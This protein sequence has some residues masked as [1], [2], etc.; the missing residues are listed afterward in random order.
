MDGSCGI[1]SYTEALL[2]HIGEAVDEDVVVLETSKQGLAASISYARTAFRVGTTD[3]DVIHVQHEYG[4]FGKKWLLLWAF[5]PIVF[6]LARLRRR[7]VVITLHEAW[8][9][10]RMDPPLL[11]L[12]GAYI[13]IAN[14]LIASTATTL[15]FLSEN[16][17][18]KFQRNGTVDDHRLL[19]HGVD[20]DEVRPTPEE[21][22]KA[23]F[24]FD[25]DDTVLTEFGYL[26]PSKGYETFLEIAE[27]CGEH[28]FLVA[29]GNPSE[30][31]YLE[32]LEADAPENVTFT[33]HLND[34]D[35]HAAFSATDVAV[36]PYSEVAQSGI[37][38][39]CAAYGLPVVASRLP[40]FERLRSEYGYPTVF[41]SVD[42][43]E[44]AIRRV[45]NDDAHRENLVSA[46]ER[47]RR[48]NDFE[49][50]GDQHEALYRRLVRS[51]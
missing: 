31:E 10:D 27:R 21:A 16:C 51:S 19:P 40:R 2:A 4:F 8:N 46:A 7:P 11:W 6:V 29:G 9:V 39:W 13:R 47:F 34:R 17:R 23:R 43:A 18:S 45:L 30:D 44:R 42:E 50:V 3:S 5:Y 15:V 33:G 48:E 35:F 49:K 28:E 22:A 24:G 20:E 41:E 25:A 14:E 38:N 26:R 36:L 12:K 32:S 1:G 37:F